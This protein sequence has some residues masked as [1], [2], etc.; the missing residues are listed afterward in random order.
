MVLYQ[1]L[2]LIMD[3]SYR[4]IIK[5]SNK[6]SSQMLIHISITRQLKL[7]VETKIVVRIII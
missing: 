3:L 7:M 2:N 5:I 1:E 4:I 6:T